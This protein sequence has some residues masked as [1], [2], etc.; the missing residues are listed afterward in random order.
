MNFKETGEFRKDFKRISK[1]Y[2][3]L[4]ED[5]KE[6]KEI[7][8]IC[9]AGVNKNFTNL[10]SA[11]NLKIIKARLFCQSLK[12]SS[13]RIIYAYHKKTNEIEFIEFVELYSK[14]KQTRESNH[15]IW[16]YLKQYN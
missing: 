10:H 4:P 11:K 3:S 8:N 7:L 9:P 16:N 13:L 15:R 1:K 14:N 12:R 5:F 6:F 2:R